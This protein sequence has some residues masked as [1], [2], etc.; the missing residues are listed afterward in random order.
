MLNLA[1]V[2]MF[3]CL[4]LKLQGQSSATSAPGRLWVTLTIRISAGTARAA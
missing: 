4:R 3:D 2:A 1:P